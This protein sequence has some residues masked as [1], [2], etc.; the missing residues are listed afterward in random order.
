MKEV[1]KLVLDGEQKIVVLSAM[2]GTTNSLVEISN[3]LYKKNSDGANE[4]INKLETKYIQEVNELY[5]TAEYKEKGLELIREHSN[6][7]K[8]FTNNIFN[9]F[10]ENLSQQV[11]SIS[12]CLS[13]VLSHV[14]CQLLSICA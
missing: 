7:I 3:Y 12:I 8:S 9:V 2:S 5:S 1:A 14:Y 11:W 4:V 13:K 6:Y 10:E